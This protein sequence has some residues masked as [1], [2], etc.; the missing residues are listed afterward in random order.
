MRERRVSKEGIARVDSF[1]R[2]TNKHFSTGKRLSRQRRIVACT[3]AGQERLLAAYLGCEWRANRHQGIQDESVYIAPVGRRAKRTCRVLKCVGL[4]D[5]VAYC[6]SQLSLFPP[7]DLF[8][9][10]SNFSSK[11]P[12]GKRDWSMVVRS[13]RTLE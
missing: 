7:N 13:V 11:H 10:N 8:P 9:T 3:I 5:F 12:G 2:S 6:G 4:V 1:L